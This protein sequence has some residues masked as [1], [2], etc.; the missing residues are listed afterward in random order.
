M[1]KLTTGDKL[2]AVAAALERKATA[3]R[4]SGIHSQNLTARRA[5]IAAGLTK[6]AETFDRNASIARALA[7]LHDEGILSRVLY[8]HVFGITT[9]KALETVLGWRSMPESGGWHGED[10]ARLLKLGI[11]TNAALS[12]AREFLLELEGPA[13]E[14]TREE[15]VRELERDL[16]GSKIPGFFPTPKSVGRRMI[17]LAYVKQGGCVLEP[18]AGKGDLVELALD[19]GARVHA[20]EVN[21]TL[22]EILRARFAGMDVVVERGDFLE[23]CSASGPIDAVVMNPPFEKGVDADHVLA[24]YRALAPGGILVAIVSEG[25]FFRNDAKARGFRK[26]LEFRDAETWKLEPGSFTGAEAFRQT[27][28]AARV[29]RILKL[30]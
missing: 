26:F 5:R 20:V 21:S 17:E 4:C 14:P 23:G 11:K 28:V 15:K 3:K 29:V 30:F 10:R 24:A 1:K 12:E 27:G 13:R 9:A 18:S 2:R 8:P 25:L 6:E 16:I 19:A 22:V 7:R